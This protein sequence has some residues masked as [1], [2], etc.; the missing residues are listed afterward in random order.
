MTTRTPSLA[1]KSEEWFASVTVTVMF[2]SSSFVTAMALMSG[3][4]LTAS[5]IRSP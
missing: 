3:A 4:P 5:P 1:W 2:P